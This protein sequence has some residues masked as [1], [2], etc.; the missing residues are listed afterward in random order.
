MSSDF[1]TGPFGWIGW[2]LGLAIFGNYI[3]WIVMKGPKR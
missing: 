2:L 3:W 1:L